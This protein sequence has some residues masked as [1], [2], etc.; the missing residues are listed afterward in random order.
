[1]RINIKT[2]PST[3]IIP[4][5]HQH[6]FTGVIHKWFGQ[7][8]FHSAVSL[9][10]F[11]SLMGGVPMN[12]GLIFRE[13]AQFFITCWEKEQSLKLIKG[14]RQNPDMFCGLKV[15]EIM[16]SETP[17][18]G[19]KTQFQ[20]GSPIFIKRTLFENEKKSLQY[21]FYDDDESSGLL[22]KTLRTKMSLA[23]IP[24][25]LFTIKFDTSYKNKKTRKIDYKK[26][27]SFITI[28]ASMCPVI[29]EGSTLIKE[30]AWSVGLGN[31]TGIGFGALK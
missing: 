22:E 13:G 27:N 28:R 4:F 12:G 3:K 17:D 1:M 24:D 26:G 18:M 11:S 14:I 19:T 29:I 9:Y 2:S 31:S 6:M 30:F 25:E 7:N 15:E 21:Y 10:S 5:N 20:L 23:N 16:I 8:D